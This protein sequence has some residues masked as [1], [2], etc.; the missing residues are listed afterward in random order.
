MH[1][2]I[3]GICKAIDENLLRNLELMQEK[4][5]IDVQMERILR[6]GYIELLRLNTYEAKKV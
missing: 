4:I 1:E 2:S 6:D 3:D 5:D